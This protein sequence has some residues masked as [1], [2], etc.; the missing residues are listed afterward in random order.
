MPVF[1]IMRHKTQK[2]HFEYKIQ[3]TKNIIDNLI[4]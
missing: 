4:F 1:P 2:F 3:N